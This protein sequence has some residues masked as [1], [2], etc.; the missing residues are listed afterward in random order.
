M[1]K[2]RLR[3]G[4]IVKMFP[5]RV[6]LARAT[7]LPVVGRLMDR[8]F[9]EGDSSVFLPHDKVVEVNR[10]IDPGAQLA[11]PSEIVELFIERSS[12][13]VIASCCICRKG[14][15]CRDYPVKLGCI[16]L[17]EAAR[18][19]DPVIGRPATKEEAIAHLRKCRDAGLIHMVGHNR[20]DALWLG[21][22]PRRKL[23]TICNCCPCCCTYK[24]LPHLDPG[25]SARI[26]RM[27]GL[28]V[29]VTEKCAGCGLCTA[30]CMVS[31]I[32]VR[33]G[34]ATISEACRGCGLCVLKCPAGAIELR[35]GDV[36][37][38]VEMIAAAAD[39]S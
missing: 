10:K 14:I 3:T 30:V 4:L 18:R 19:I 15:G 33:D 25:I 38:T 31:A 9:Y 26:T 13:R 22:Q 36:N 6:P 37:R 27:P 24:I 16:F 35:L 12:H 32:A 20:F 21:V 28:T 11:L 8:L 5:W 34:K 1:S 2:Q 39:I 17:G 7:R 29:A 23:L